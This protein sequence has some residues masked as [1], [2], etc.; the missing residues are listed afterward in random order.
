MLTTDASLSQHTG[1]WRLM[2]TVSRWGTGWWGALC[3][4]RRWCG[5]STWCFFGPHRRSTGRTGPTSGAVMWF[6][7]VGTGAATRTWCR[8]PSGTRTGWAI[9]TRTS[10]GSIGQEKNQSISQSIFKILGSIRFFMFLKDISYAH[11][12]WIY[13]IKNTVKN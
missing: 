8:A 10:S 7:A 1:E 9:W 4:G 3:W 6:G 12:Q 5:F 2:T 11:Q 13:F